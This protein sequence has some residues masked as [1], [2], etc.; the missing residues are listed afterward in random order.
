M[1][2]LGAPEFMFPLLAA[3]YRAPLG[4]SDFSLHVSGPTGEGKTELGSLA[5]QHYGA[6]LDA[7]HTVSWEATENAL[8]THAF[9]LKDQLFVIDDFNPVGSSTD[10][11]RWHKKADRV[12]R[13]KGNAAGRQRLRADLTLRPE[14]PPRALIVSTGEDNPSGQSLRARMLICELGKGQVDF[15]VLTECQRDAA[16]GEYAASMAGYVEFLSLRYEEIRA[17]L[18]AERDEL[19]DLARS[20][21][22]HRRTT[23]IVAD[24]ALGLRYFLRYA[25]DAGAFSREEAKELWSRGWAALCKV[26]EEQAEHQAASEPTERFSEL[27]RAAISGGQAHVA[28]PTNADNMPD[29]ARGWGWWYE[30]AGDDEAW[31]PKGVRIGWIRDDG[32]YLQPDTALKLARDM[33]RDSSDPITLTKTTLGKRLR[34]KGLLLSTGAG[35]GRES[36]TVRRKFEGR[37][38]A[39]LHVPVAYL[40]PV[41]EKPDQPDHD[42][43]YPSS[44]ANSCGQVPE[45]EPD[46][47]DKCGQ[48][49]DHET[50]GQKCT[51]KSNCLCE[52]CL[53]I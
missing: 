28:D 6:G 2:T 46:H 47:G 18:K 33:G 42:A 22:Q 7:R 24:L 32:L 40:S 15:G 44:H 35:E 52:E 34:D 19:R 29:D 8:E 26:G 37:Q 30:T 25:I 36:I 49:P 45:F 11:Q 21:G 43:R 39:Y 17:G 1:L 38:D 53:P 16:E 14:K 4:E 51:G 3:T 12:M 13:A 10:I 41:G 23:N 27:L 5:Q 31:R 48:E 20:R 9:V 50:R